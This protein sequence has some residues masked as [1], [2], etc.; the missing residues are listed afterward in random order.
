MSAHLHPARPA[1][2]SGRFA[3]LPRPA[4]PTQAF[5]G[6]KGPSCPHR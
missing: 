6:A 3:R 2:S 5:P 1:L 4:G